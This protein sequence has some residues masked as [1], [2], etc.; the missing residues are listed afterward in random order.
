MPDH[1]CIFV[2]PDGRVCKRC[3]VL[4]RSCSD[5][6][7][8]G[9]SAVDM[10]KLLS[11]TQA[12]PAK[13]PSPLPAHPS[14]SMLQCILY[15]HYHVSDIAL[16]G[17]GPH[18][19]A[20]DIPHTPISIGA[21]HTSLPSM[22]PPVAPHHMEAVSCSSLL[23]DSGTDKLAFSQVLHCGP[24]RAKTPGIHDGLGSVEQGGLPFNIP[25]SPNSHSP[26]VLTTGPPITTGPPTAPPTPPT[27]P[28]FEQDGCG[29]TRDFLDV[30]H[31]PGVC[32][33][34]GDESRLQH[35]PC[36]SSKL[37]PRPQAKTHSAKSCSRSSSS[38]AQSIAD[39]VEDSLP[40]P[41]V[42]SPQR[43]SSVRPLGDIESR[44]QSGKPF[45][46]II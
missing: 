30:P 38:S 24:I 7:L 5:A 21:S 18:N 11:P 8:R 35:L 17:P 29:P 44:A 19:G 16:A 23:A 13:Q 9:R 1:K 33:I 6:A 14:S 26:M 28:A 25:S 45:E 12:P 43:P 34:V 10:N 22:P 32:P 2:M 37:S 42:S 4:H 41:A 36:P 46:S 27:P 39:V 40:P 3:F 15:W 20:L 31:S